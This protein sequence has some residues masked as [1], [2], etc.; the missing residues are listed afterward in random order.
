MT[1]KK[2]L[3]CG[4]EIEYN[5]GRGGHNKKYCNSKCFLNDYHK[6]EKYK[7]YS[8][9]WQLNYRKTEK[10]KAR[11]KKFNKEYWLEHEK[12]NPQ[13]IKEK[14]EYQKQ[15]MKTPKMREWRRNY[16]KVTRDR[17]IIKIKAKSYVWRHKLTDNHCHWCN[18]KENLNFHH[19]D[20]IE[21]TGFTLCRQCHRLLHK[22]MMLGWA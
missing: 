6:T 8:R 13:Y 19:T 14:L 1:N 22:G 20:Y 15:Y 21:N 3:G 18:N 10:G 9:T 5:K 17:D 12:N 16:D 4:K 7:L 2:C 11:Y